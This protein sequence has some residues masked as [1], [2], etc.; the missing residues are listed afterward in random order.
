METRLT[1]L[2][3]LRNIHLIWKTCN[4]TF[5]YKQNDCLNKGRS[6]VLVSP[7]LLSNY[8][9]YGIRGMR[10]CFITGYNS[11]RPGKFHFWS[12][13]KRMYRNDD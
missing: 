4:A 8:S 7:H 5:E 10:T 13:Y 6:F 9:V 12:S 2:S 1:L 3:T 11:Y